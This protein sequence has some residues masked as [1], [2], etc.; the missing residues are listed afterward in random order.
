MKPSLYPINSLSVLEGH[1]AMETT[2]PG[3]ILLES[4][5]LREGGGGYGG[6]E[7]RE[8]EREGGDGRE[9]GGEGRRRGKGGREEEM[10]GR[11]EER[12]GGRR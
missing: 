10:E 2:E 8:E 11:E 9:G 1:V 4:W 12:E 6:R 5:I 3:W 7:G